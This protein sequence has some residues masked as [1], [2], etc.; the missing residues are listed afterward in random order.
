MTY[1]III[2]YKRKIIGERMNNKIFL[3]ILIGLTISLKVYS[4]PGADSL[5]LNEAVRMT[6]AVS[7][8]IQQAYHMLNASEA[9]V[10]QS[11]SPL[12][13]QADV[14]LNY[15]WI[16]P[17]PAFSFPG[18]GNIVLAPGN[19]WDEHLAVSSTIYDFDKRG[20]NVEYAKSQVQGFRDR[21]EFIRQDLAYKTVQN[22]Y[23]VLF[24]KKSIEVQIDQINTLKKH[25]DWTKKKVDAGT[26]T[27]F[28]L[29]T[30]QVR[31][32]SAENSR[33]SLENSLESS[34]INLRRLLGL[35]PN[36]EVNPSGRFT[37]IPVRVNFDSLFAASIGNRI[38]I[39]SAED[40]ISVAKAQYEVAS[41]INNPSV[42]VAFIYGFKNGYEPNLYSWRGNFALAAQVL[43]PV[44]KFVPF[45]GGYK[46]ESMHQEA[47]ANMKAAESNRSETVEQIKAEI[48][49]AVSDIR[50]SLEKIHTTE[51]SITQAESALNLA[52][53]RFDAGT[54]TNIDLL[55]TQTSLSEAKLMR[56]EALY[57]YVL[58]VYELKQASGEKIW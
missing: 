12:Y 15:T 26:A 46:E 14:S 49:K 54:I 43:I 3:I 44:S 17:I 30:T 25:Y 34:E 58:G 1:K 40:Q 41:N 4:Q 11:R 38:E 13:P 2:K 39:K 37:D 31:I 45:F 56:L 47:V 51:A 10:D 33:I 22:F 52:K 36:A 48:Q 57:R 27:E 7:N 35:A 29:L 16:G 55:D 53:I 9:R 28:D 32:S 19:N 24:L 21:I 23:S 20:K 18:F 6:L 8:S 50:S 42:N 5:K